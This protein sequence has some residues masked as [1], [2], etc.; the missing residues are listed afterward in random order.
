[1][2]ILMGQHTFPKAIALFYSSS[3]C[4]VIQW[5]SKKVSPDTDYNCHFAPPANAVKIEGVRSQPKKSTLGWY[6]HCKSY[7]RGIKWRASFAVKSMQRL[8]FSNRE[9]RGLGC[10]LCL[11][12]HDPSSESA[13]AAC[14]WTQADPEG[15]RGSVP[16]PDKMSY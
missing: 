5:E 16:G 9:H 8:V 6:Q 14:L 12:K 4:R 7:I 10:C 2:E 13:L 15:S 1:M 11:G 3:D